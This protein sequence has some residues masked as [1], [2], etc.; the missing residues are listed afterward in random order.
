ADLGRPCLHSMQAIVTHRMAPSFEI[1][2]PWLEGGTGL[3]QSGHIRVDFARSLFSF[4]GNSATGAA[5]L[6]HKRDNAVWFHAR[7]K[8][9]GRRPGWVV[10]TLVSTDRAVNTF[11]KGRSACPESGPGSAA[12]CGLHRRR[13]PAPAQSRRRGG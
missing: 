4:L 1:A 11:G 7:S 3:Y 6:H 2:Y 10:V 12:G 13:S 9:P 5:R 8:N